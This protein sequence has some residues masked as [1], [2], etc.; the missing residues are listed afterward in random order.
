MGESKPEER[1]DLGKIS[2]NADLAYRLA[3][4]YCRM[5]LAETPNDRFSMS[6]VDV[7]SGKHG[8]KEV[9]NRIMGLQLEYE[10]RMHAINARF[11]SMDGYREYRLRKYTHPEFSDLKDYMNKNFPDLRSYMRRND[12]GVSGNLRVGS[13]IFGPPIRIFTRPAYHG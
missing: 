11:G 7:L 10:R 6:I 8:E 1:K 13:F 3:D 12:M 5:F 2:R 9:E 4:L